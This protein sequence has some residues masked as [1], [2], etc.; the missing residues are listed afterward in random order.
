MWKFGSQVLL[1]VVM[2]KKAGVKARRPDGPGLTYWQWSWASRFASLN[3][4][5]LTYKT[6]IITVPESLGCLEHEMK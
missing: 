4:S 2:K 3:L 6:G 5:F 1:G